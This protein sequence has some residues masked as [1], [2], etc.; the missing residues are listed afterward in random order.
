M[1]QENAVLTV[2]RS[3]ES[4]AGE[5]CSDIRTY[6]ENNGIAAAVAGD[7]TPGVVS[8]TCEVR[9]AASDADRASELIASLPE[10]LEEV[11]PS[12][13]LDLVSIYRSEATPNA[14]LEAMGL[15]AVLESNEIDSVLMGG[16][17]MPN[18]PVEV[19][20]A[21]EDE[22]RARAAIA[23]AAAAGPEAADAAEL[24]TEPQP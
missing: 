2:F 16:S 3:A 11:D 21:S 19:R 15:K 7:D 5:E 22:E 8:G 13:D 4:L 6:L 9:V 17:M 1:E 20:V 14:E 24:L 23:A 10:D 12:H 18:L